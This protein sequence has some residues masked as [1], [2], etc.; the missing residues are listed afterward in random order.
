MG[1]AAKAV[2]DVV[3]TTGNI[4]T[5]VTQPVEKAVTQATQDL[6]LTPKPS[7]S[8]VPDSARQQDI[9]IAMPLN[10]TVPSPPTSPAPVTS[11]PADPNGSADLA[12]VVYGPDGKQYGSPA[13]ARSAG[14][15]NYTMSPP[16]P[17]PVT[18]P[19]VEVVAPPYVPYTPAPA[20][21][22]APPTSPYTAPVADTSSPTSGTSVR[23]LN[24]PFNTNTTSNPSAF[25]PMKNSAP[26]PQQYNNANAF[27]QVFNPTPTTLPMYSPTGTQ[28]NGNTGMIT[29]VPPA[30]Q[31][32][33]DFNSSYNNLLSGYYSNKPM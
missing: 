27:N 33:Q 5:Q 17:A 11:A 12:V 10:G 22:P 16:A 29:P 21:T 19:P 25:Q 18:P 9:Q 31:N 7:S 24:N 23:F 28:I 4:V 15:T 26:M 8:A 14:V 20:P 30:P 2:E 6:G 3:N 13:A 32:N 1:G